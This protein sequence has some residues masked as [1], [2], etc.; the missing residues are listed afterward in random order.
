MLQPASPTAQNSASAPRWG[1]ARKSCTAGDPSRW[2]N[3]LLRS[4]RS[5]E[6]GRFGDPEDIVVL[7]IA[8]IGE[9]DELG[10]SGE[11]GDYAARCMPTPRLALPRQTSAPRP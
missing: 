9:N 8:P 11:V 10:A 2:R 1:S 7:V 6:W 3:S 5:W 4:T